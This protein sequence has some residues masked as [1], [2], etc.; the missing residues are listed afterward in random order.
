MAHP[1]KIVP[2]KEESPSQEEAPSSDSTSKES[3]QP[4]IMPSSKEKTPMCMV[5]ELARFNK[6]SAFYQHTVVDL[7]EG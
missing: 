5:N 3:A 2:E 7:G 4:S 1:T 6:V